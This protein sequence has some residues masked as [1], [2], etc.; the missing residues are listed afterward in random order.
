MP[1]PNFSEPAFIQWALDVNRRLAGLEQAFQ[2]VKDAH[3]ITRVKTGLLPGGD[4]GVAVS[5]V[6]G[7]T[8]EILPIYELNVG[9][10][11]STNSTAYTD[12]A[13]PGPLVTAIVGAGGQVL[14][15]VNSY[16]GVPGVASAQSG[17][18]V[19]LSIDGAAPSGSLDELLYFSVS[20]G[21]QAVGVAANQSSQII[22]TTGPGSHTF[23]MKY[24]TVGGATVTFA[25][26]F[27]QVRP[28]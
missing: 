1:T 5:D 23:E 20:S 18:F 4:Y 24:K 14:L 21:T 16:I 3:G 28:I 9:A 12:L 11:E 27:L 8:T 2:G 25:E 13:T 17:G 22:V 7:V 15:T 19:G 10:P 6:N 26:R